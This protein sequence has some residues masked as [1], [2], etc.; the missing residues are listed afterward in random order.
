MKSACYSAPPELVPARSA[1]AQILS[2]PLLSRPAYWE[3]DALAT[4][5][6]EPLAHVPLRT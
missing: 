2:V 3:Y 4:N 1:G 6:I 5:G